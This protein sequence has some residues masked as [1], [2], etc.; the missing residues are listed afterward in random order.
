MS[1]EVKKSNVLGNMLLAAQEKFGERSYMGKDCELYLTGFPFRHLSLRWLFDS[2]VFPVGK[3]IRIYGLPRQ[4]KSTLSYEF[5]RLFAEA[6]CDAMGY[7]ENE[8]GK[9]SPSLFQSFL[10]DLAVMVIHSKTTQ[11]AQMALNMMKKEIQKGYP[12][13][14]HLSC[15]VLDSLN[16]TSAESKH[17]QLNKEDHMTKSYP[18]EANLWS[19]FL[20]TFT[21]ELLGW[22]ITLIM[23]NHLKKDVSGDGKPHFGGPKMRTPGGD[24]Q[25]FHSA[26]DIR[27]ARDQD[28]KPFQT[29]SYQG[30]VITRTHN[31]L[32]MYLKTDKSSIGSD[33]QRVTVNMIFWNDDNNQQITFFD[34]WGADAALLH[35]MEAGGEHSPSIGNR[36]AL[37]DICDVDVSRG[38]YTSK[39]L[40]LKGVTDHEFGWELQK[41]P[42]ML[43]ALSKVCGVKNHPIFDGKMPE[44]IEQAAKRKKK[45]EQQAVDLI[46][47]AE[48]AKSPLDTYEGQVSAP[49]GRASTDI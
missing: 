33:N 21:A 23:T 6:G 24:A 26:V 30:R 36:K 11:E 8:A 47:V 27:V 5:M 17:E 35:A 41:H 31:R 18:E 40:G 34:W 44:A 9:Y 2:N 20:Q 14:D 4:Q 13:R 48:K 49:K 43:D 25:H 3:L 45:A 16:G 39:T 15:L 19:Q 42:D 46:T 29:L 7:V 1:K 10:R 28:F 12:D 32:R 22:P 38:L 37:A